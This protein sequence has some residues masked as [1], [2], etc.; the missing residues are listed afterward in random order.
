MACLSQDAQHD[1]PFGLDVHLIRVVLNCC[2]DLRQGQL[3]H[4]GLQ[5]YQQG[6]L[7]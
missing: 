5:Y 7:S 4:M 1:E 2:Q 6:E 3:A